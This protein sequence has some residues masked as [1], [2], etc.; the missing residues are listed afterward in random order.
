MKKNGR[1]KRQKGLV[2]G[3]LELCAIQK[4]IKNAFEVNKNHKKK[5]AT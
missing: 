1:S 5:I 4:I 3:P 2:S